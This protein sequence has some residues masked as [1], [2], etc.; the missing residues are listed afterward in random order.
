MPYGNRQAASTALDE[1]QFKANKQRL[2]NRHT[3]AV[4][5]P[6]IRVERW[7]ALRLLEQKETVKLPLS[8]AQCKFERLYL[9]PWWLWQSSSSF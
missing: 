9:Q 6:S 2:D 8:A 4:A 3:V 1:K 5:T 7:G